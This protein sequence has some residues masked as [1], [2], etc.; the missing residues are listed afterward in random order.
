MGFVF[1]GCIDVNVLLEG[2]EYI[3]VLFGCCIVCEWKVRKGKEW[4]GGGVLGGD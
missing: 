4:G 2:V 1:G 3:W